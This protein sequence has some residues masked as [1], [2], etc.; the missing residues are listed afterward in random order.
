MLGSR[1]TYGGGRPLIGRHWADGLVFL[2]AI[3]SSCGGDGSGPPPNVTY[4]SVT[5]ITPSKT[6]AGVTLGVAPVVTFS[7]PLNP[8][9][10]SAANITL[11]SGGGAQSAAAL[12]VVGNQVTVTPNWKLTPQTTYSLNISTAVQSTSGASLASAAILQFTT[13]TGWDT[14]QLIG[15]GS[16]GSVGFEP[17]GNALAVL[18]GAQLTLNEYVM[19]RGWGTPGSPTALPQGAFQAVV[20]PGGGAL[21]TFSEQSSLTGNYVWS[22]YAQSFTPAVGWGPAHQLDTLFDNFGHQLAADASGNALFVHGA[23]A[24]PNS[25][26]GTA[27]IYANRYTPAGGW[28]VDQQLSA[29]PFL[30]GPFLAMNAKGNGVVMWSDTLGQVFADLFAPATGWSM[31]QMIGTA[32]FHKPGFVQFGSVAISA[33]GNAVAYWLVGGLQAAGLVASYYTPAGG[34]SGAQ[35]MFNFNANLLI[36]PPYSAVLAM[37][38][39]GNMLAATSVDSLAPAG[40]AG[41]YVASY[42]LGTG[43]GTALQV[44]NGSAGYPWSIAID[45]HGDA[46]LT[47]VGQRSPAP[48]N[49]IHYT[50][51][52]GWGPAVPLAANVGVTGSVAFDENGNAFTSWCQSVGNT[53]NTYADRFE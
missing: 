29:A 16:C 1:K 51:G 12:S 44:D 14:P 46:L 32:Y 39:N 19:G 48:I 53:E 42:Q 35:N 2:A 18:S 36:N 21:L 10:V 4:M 47:L 49:A 38:D 28:S 20:L 9:T 41:T 50:A 52:N 7:A 22:P 27:Q 24:G 15:A 5:G 11:T 45:S 17:N 40:S 43:W 30:D 13:G 3:L 6:A 25:L 23:V 8:A 37:D 26:P 31:P 33:N 34:W